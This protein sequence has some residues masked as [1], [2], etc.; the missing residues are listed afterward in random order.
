[1]GEHNILNITTFGGCSISYGKFAIGDNGSGSSK[2]WNLLAYLITNRNREITMSELL[3]VLWED[4]EEVNNPVG[5]LKVLVHRARKALGELGLDGKKIILSRQ[6][7]Y[8]FDCGGIETHVDAEAFESLYQNAEKKQFDKS[9]LTDLLKA[10]ELY[11]GD[12]LPNLLSVKW[13]MPLSVYYNYKYISVVSNALNI[14][15]SEGRYE[16]VIELSRKAIAISPYDETLHVQLIDALRRLGRYQLALNHYNFVTDMLYQQFA[17]TPSEELKAL[18][19]EIIKQTNLEETSISEVSDKIKSGAPERGA[20]YCTPQ[21]F[22]EICRYDA[23]TKARSG[24]VAFLCLITVRADKSEDKPLI[25]S[26]VKELHI[27]IRDSLRCGD[28]FTLLSTTQFGILLQDITYEMGRKVLMRVITAYHRRFPGRKIK[29]NF[30]LK[31]LE[32][33]RSAEINAA[34]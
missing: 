22:Q 26:A 24:G 33:F 14:L 16:E 19:K 18:Y 6:G 30:S 1:M 10:A 13:V 15:S 20:Y 3:N 11:K 12:F 27:A 23:R 28:C 21:V 2:L 25:S 5:A 4:D 32:S 7:S 8:C 29:L 9:T 34:R 31:Q 17:I